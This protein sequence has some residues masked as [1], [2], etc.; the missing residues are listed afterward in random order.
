MSKASTSN[1]CP[2]TS[3]DGIHK[4][5]KRGLKRIEDI[6]K[7]CSATKATFKPRGHPYWRTFVQP[8]TLKWGGMAIPTDFAKEHD[9]ANNCGEVIILDERGKTWQLSLRKYKRSVYIG[10]W[11]HFHRQND[12]SAGDCLT[13]EL[14]NTG[15]LPV[16]K[17]YRT[18]S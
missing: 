14:I 15:E 13:F 1:A 11:S 5:G 6:H 4:N 7:A 3:T 16:M 12:L 9:L 2:I 17:F 10:R 8:S 18:V